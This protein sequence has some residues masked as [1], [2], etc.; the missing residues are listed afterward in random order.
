MDTTVEFRI[1]GEVVNPDA[2]NRPI[3]VEIFSNAR[4]AK[5]TLRNPE[6]RN[7]LNAELCRGIQLAVERVEHEG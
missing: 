2:E 7:A 5:M 1:D 6:R 3:L 4:I